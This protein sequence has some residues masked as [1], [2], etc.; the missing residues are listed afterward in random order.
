MAIIGTCLLRNVS[1]YV[2]FDTYID[3]LYKKGGNDTVY[4]RF[5]YKKKKKKLVI[6]NTSRFFFN[7]SWGVN[8]Y[9]FFEFKYVNFCCCA[10]TTFS[11]LLPNVSNCFERC[12]PHFPSII[13][14]RYKWYSLYEINLVISR[15]M[16]LCLTSN[17]FVILNE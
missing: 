11:H 2:I 5:R 15:T 7:V 9:L 10:L 3:S 1:I 16:F 12:I 17:N 4:I 14:N 6:N 8:M 13:K